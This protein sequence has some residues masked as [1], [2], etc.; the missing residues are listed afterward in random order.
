MLIKWRPISY[1]SVMIIQWDKGLKE[2]KL[3]IMWGKKKNL[4]INFPPYPF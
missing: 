3:V 4:R 1:D 2:H